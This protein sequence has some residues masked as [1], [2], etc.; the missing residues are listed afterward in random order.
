MRLAHLFGFEAVDCVSQQTGSS[1]R[2]PSDFLLLM[3]EVPSQ[4][5][6]LEKVVQVHLS[7]PALN[8]VHC[9]SPDKEVRVWIRPV[10]LKL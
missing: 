7:V 9:L 8:S 2:P 4:P 5:D 6:H 3:P 10:L 1:R